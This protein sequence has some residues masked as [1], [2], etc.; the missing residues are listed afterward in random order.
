MTYPVGSPSDG[1]LKVSIEANGHHDP[2]LHSI[3]HIA[4]AVHKLDDAIHLFQDVLGFKLRRRLHIK[5]K[6]TG[7]VCADMVRNDMC[8]VLCQGTEPESQVSQL[9]QNCGVGL[10]H[11]ALAVDD[12]SAAVNTLRERGLSFDTTIIEGP[13]LTQAFSSRCP[14][15]GISFE[16]IHRNGEEAFLEN[17]VQELFEQLEQAGKY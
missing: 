6:K 2:R 14:N 10:A 5:G 11:V 15:T 16:L 4:L 3:D 17:N 1:S 12:V 7:M 13:G 9:V 8:F